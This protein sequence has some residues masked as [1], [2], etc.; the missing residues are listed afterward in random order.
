MNEDLVRAAVAAGL[1]GYGNADSFI[2]ALGLGLLPD[3]EEPDG[4][5]YRRG[6][7]GRPR[8]QRW[9]RS[10]LEEL[11]ARRSSTP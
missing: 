5:E 11:A 8:Q 7:A 6:S 9:R 3:V 2:R 1:V 4:F 10:R